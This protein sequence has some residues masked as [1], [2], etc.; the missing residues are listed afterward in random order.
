[1]G[2]NSLFKHWS[3]RIFAPGVVL[4]QTY[5]AFKDLLEQ[6]GRC[7]ELM[8][9]FEVLFYENLHE[10]F[11]RIRRRYARFSDAVL[12]MIHDLELMQPGSTVT[13]QAYYKK[14]DFYIRFLLAPPEPDIAPPFV[15]HLGDITDP[16]RSGN[17]AY[18]LAILKNSLKLPVPDGFVINTAAY[19]YLLEYNDLR[20]RINRL[21]AELDI[22]S[23]QSLG[24]VSAQLMHLMMQADVPED[25][26]DLIFGFYDEMEKKRGATILTAVRSSACSEDGEFSF[27][28]QY[29][30]VLGVHRDNV[31]DAYLQV[32]ASR[33]TP[34]A[35][36]YRV[37]LGISDEETPI[38]VLVL[39]MVDACA[40]GVA[41]TRSPS[42]EA[43]D[44]IVI[45]SVTGL[46]EPLVGG[47]A[48]PD[49][50]YI[51]RRENTLSGR[52]RGSQRQKLV[53]SGDHVET[54]SLTAHDKKDFALSTAQ[55]LQV[56]RF[57]LQIEKFFKGPQD[58]E[59]AALRG[60][61]LFLLQARPLRLEEPSESIAR[62]ME[63]DVDVQPLV[64]G[65]K[66][67]APGCASG[68]VFVLPGREITEIPNNAVLVTINTPP[69]L[70]SVLDRL[71]AVVADQGATAGH[72]ATVCREFGVP[73]LVG[74]ENA[75]STLRHGESVTVAADR[76]A[77]Y[78]GRIEPLLTRTDTMKLREQ[79]PYY[80]K[81]KGLLDFITP[82]KLHDPYAPDFKPESCRSMH[83]IIRYVH[84]QAVRTM[85]FLGDRVGS[86]SGKSKK[87]VSRLPIDVYLLDVG[88]GIET[89]GGD[90]ETVRVD[91]V[92]SLPF[93]AL[94]KG[95]SHPGID[96]KSHAHFDWKTF[97]EVALAGGIAASGSAD[98][99]SY[100]LISRDYLNL[101]MRFGYHFTLIDVLCSEDSRANY[102]R[103]RFAGGG[104]EYG[105]RALRIEFLHM[106]LVRL[107]MEV[108]IRADLLDA[109]VAEMDQN[110][111]CEL[112]DQLGRLLGASKL[113]DMVLK[114]EEDVQEFVELFFKEQYTFT[115]AMA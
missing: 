101:N 92:R 18:N 103:L 76:L 63:E 85:F 50:F 84:E 58:I 68:K 15:Q 91:Q 82:L 41:Y 96:W 108:H 20:P 4:R 23:Q 69:S 89:K 19:N 109:A 29:R 106:V 61:E 86:R 10:D 21:L 59:W 87:L 67:A 22:S 44:R 64:S 6:D 3:Y 33:F 52:Q 12:A 99:A 35:M 47:T 25:I 54:V 27:A 104:G 56:A 16:L 5:D 24:A 32:L 65:G 57:G 60:G 45:Q 51:D 1:M 105:G 80:K 78:P 93:K 74:T 95:L 48:D 75:T 37:R 55:A 107:G 17:K 14:F 40:S 110:M 100:A 98:L 28:G 73:L 36:S 8:A 77:V 62:E 115:A 13:L 38:A 49:I 72:F 9:G 31:L 114:E 111:L 90:Q 26:T 42:G 11:S 43:G 66:K 39:A 112:L 2:L 88:Q 30:S 7:H 97:D 71:V 46:G 70:V 79:L 113:M 83:D 94:W 34:E 102:C 53:L 81:T